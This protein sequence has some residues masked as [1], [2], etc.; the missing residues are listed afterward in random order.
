[1]ADDRQQQRL[2]QTFEALRQALEEAESALIEYEESHYED[3]TVRPQSRKGLGLLSIPE[4][5]QELGMGKSWVYTRIRSGEIPSVKLGH[6]IK[7]K[8]EALEGYLDQLTYRPSQDD[9]IEGEGQP[10]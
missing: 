4:V 10:T 1:M 5:C 6:N 2:K 9:P 3:S 8:R 7:V